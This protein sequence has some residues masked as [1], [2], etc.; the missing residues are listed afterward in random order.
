MQKPATILCIDDDL[1]G[2]YVRRLLL[3]SVGFEVVCAETGE[4]GIDLFRSSDVA[5]VVLDYFMPGMNG[6]EVAKKLRDIAPNVPIILL[7]AYLEIP[8]NTRDVVDGYVRKGQDPRVLLTRI[9]EL[10]EK[11]FGSGPGPLEDESLRG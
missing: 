3:E 2:L 6:G 9:K 4:Q 11:R 1:A 8:D 5:V 10:L 7:S